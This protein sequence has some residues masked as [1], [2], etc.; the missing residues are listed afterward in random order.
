MKKSKKEEFSE[1]FNDN[2]SSIM[3]RILRA[4]GI[5]VISYIILNL[6]LITTDNGT[7]VPIIIFIIVLIAIIF[8]ISYIKSYVE[9]KEREKKRKRKRAEMKRRRAEQNFRNI[10]N[11]GS[12]DNSNRE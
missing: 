1:I 12:V 11:Q 9:M 8:G 5:I 2:F 6:M 3:K 10:N 4:L 7:I